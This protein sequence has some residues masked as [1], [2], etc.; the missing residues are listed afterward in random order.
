[1][2]CE[3]DLTVVDRVPYLFS[4]GSMAGRDDDLPSALSFGTITT[5]I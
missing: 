1:M 5:A 2:A 4:S 3:I